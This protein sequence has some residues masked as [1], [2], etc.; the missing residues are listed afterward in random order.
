MNKIKILFKPSP[1][2]SSL[3]FITLSL[4]IAVSF[5]LRDLK[6]FE[7][8]AQHPVIIENIRIDK[9]GQHI[10]L[11]LIDL[12]LKNRRID[13]ITP[14]SRRGPGILHSRAKERRLTANTAPAT[15]PSRRSREAPKVLPKSNLKTMTAER[16]D[17]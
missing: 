10:R 8:I 17:Q 6:H 12:S 14:A 4:I 15:V 7:A 9:E 16:T 13:L 2:L 3:A 1:V 5:Y 11:C